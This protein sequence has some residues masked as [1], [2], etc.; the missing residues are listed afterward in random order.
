M[1]TWNALIGDVNRAIAD[2]NEEG[3]KANAAAAQAGEAA[4][5]AQDAADAA[6]EAAQAAQD[7]AQATQDERYKWEN[8]TAGV[9]T[10]EADE[11]AAL[12]LSE[13]GGVKHFAFAVPRGVTGA[14]GAKGAPGVSGVTF[15]LTGTSLY[16]RRTT[17]GA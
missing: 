1:S 4:A 13:T 16:I 11:D 10:L 15:T 3:S 14:D 2:M 7:A 6:Q 12:T 8:A 17:E 5:A 9:R